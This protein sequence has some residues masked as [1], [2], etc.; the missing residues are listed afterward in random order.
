TLHNEDELRRKDVRIGDWVFVRRA[1]DVIPE[2]VKVITTKRTGSEREFVFPTRCPVCNAAAVKEPEGAILR[3]TNASCPAQLEGHLQH[4]ASRT[5]MDIEG[6]GEKLSAQL[7]ST[8]TVKTLADLYRL[9]LEKLLTLERMGEKSAL[10]LLEG[11][12]RSKKC[13][14]RRFLYALGIRHV[15]EAT[16]KALAEHFRDTRA[17]LDASEDDLMRVRDVGPEMARSIHAFLQEPQNRAVI[18][19]LLAAGVEPTPPEAVQGGAFSGKTVVLTGGLTLLTREQAKEE[20]ERRGGRISGSVSRKTDYVVAGE[21]AG[22]KLKKAQELGLK[23]L[24][25]KTF[26]ALLNGGA[27]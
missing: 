19:E 10:N 24:D 8:G 20:I 15:G 26:V 4:F 16:A 21:D 23:V 3:C 12:T 27:R 14:L 1:G 2:I 9:D 7:V 13:A 11:I 6:L 22:S 5:A 17:M 25:E 18:E